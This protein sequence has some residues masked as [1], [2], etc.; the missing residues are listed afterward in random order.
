[1]DFWVFLTQGLSQGAIQGSAG[2][3]SPQGWT[4]GW[5]ILGSLTWLLEGLRSPTSKLTCVA[6]AGCRFSWVVGQDISSLP[7]GPLHRPTHNMAACFP[8]SR[9]SKKKR[10]WTK[11][12]ERGRGSKRGQATQMPESLGNLTSP[13]I[14][15]NFCYILFDRSK[16][17]GPAYCR[18]GDY[19]QAWIPG[20][21]IGTIG[22]RFR[23]CPP[24]QLFRMLI[25][26]C[27][28]GLKMLMSVGWLK[29]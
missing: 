11:E 7:H 15:C 24:H 17:P 10:E 13:L 28:W 16:S 5:L 14:S 20:D 1:M 12:R 4:V 2:L 9:G 25:L 8:Q 6:V 21:R 27:F 3:Q 23:G 26:S 19:T 22:S 18:R 29:I